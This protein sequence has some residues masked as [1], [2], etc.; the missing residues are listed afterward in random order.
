MD[1]AAPAHLLASW[2]PE[3][4]KVGLRRLG[5]NH[6]VVVRWSGRMDPMDEN[7][8][9]NDAARKALRDM[10]ACTSVP[11]EWIGAS[12][13][14]DGWRLEQD[15]ETGR[16]DI[17][18]GLDHHPEALQDVLEQLLPYAPIILWPR[19]DARP[20]DVRLQVQVERHWQSLPA[21]FAEAYR[22]RWS[23]GHE[24]CKA[25]LGELRAVWHDE[26]WL[27]F[28]RPFEQRIVASPEEEL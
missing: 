28:C 14:E 21:G 9:L 1:V 5:V 11:V 20:G 26:A 15:L 23:A 16:Y 18:V 2:Q 10:A 8:E 7:A 3:E 22:N 27:E 24:D 12:V 13:L 17:A 6:T 25:C 19:P 4:D